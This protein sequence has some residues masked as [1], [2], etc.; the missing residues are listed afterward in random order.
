MSV[1][2]ERLGRWL[3]GFAQRHGTTTYDVRPERA[4]VRAADGS[5]AEV[6][7]PFAPLARQDLDGLLAHVLAE[8]TVALLLV[9]RGGFAVGVT[10][11][12]R[13]VAS[14]VGGRHVQGR[15]AAGGWSQQRFARRREGQT[16]VATAA[17]ADEAVRVLGPYLA[18]S[19]PAVVA[20]APAGD[21]AMVD[22]VLG[23]P[24]L[25]RLAALPRVPLGH[26]G[27]PR[28]AVLE[29][30]AR[31]TR[32]VPVL[33]HETED[34]RPPRASTGPTTPARGT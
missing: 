8:R 27:E 30:A 14:K 32:A 24:R 28:R 10:T 17:A 31:R 20:L 26:V 25:A 12:E 11:G 7:V 9:R 4:T 13:L 1:A 15:T 33:L 18:G 29:E 21:A 2:P 6:E 34:P 3:E 19:V 5:V 23:D 22:A 16:R